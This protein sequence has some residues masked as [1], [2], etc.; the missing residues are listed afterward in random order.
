MRPSRKK[1]FLVLQRVPSL[2]MEHVLLS[3]SLLLE[4]ARIACA[5]NKRST[6]CT[7]QKTLCASFCSRNTLLF[8]WRMLCSL[9]LMDRISD[10]D[11]T[12]EFRNG[13]FHSV[14][15]CQRTRQFSCPNFNKRCVCKNPGQSGICRT[16]TSALFPSESEADFKILVSEMQSRALHC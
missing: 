6:L 16:N 2:F 10:R 12:S 8:P 3:S 14:S 9:P 5:D 1:G 15:I 7:I 11:S 4:E 13:S